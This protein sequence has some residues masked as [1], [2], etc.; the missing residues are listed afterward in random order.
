MLISEPQ[1]A[2]CVDD[3]SLYY[4][5]D[6]ATSDS[7]IL[8]FYGPAL[9]GNGNH[10]GWRIQAHIYTP[11]GVRSYSRITTSPNSAL[12][13]VVSYL[14]EEQQGDEVRRALS[15]A[16]FKYFSDLSEP[17]RTAWRNDGELSQR[18][19]TFDEAHAA[20]LAAKMVKAE[21]T[22]DVYNDV[23]AAFAERSLS[24]LDLDVLV[25]DPRSEEGNTPPVAAEEAAWDDPSDTKYGAYASLVRLFGSPAFLPTSKLQRAPSRP[26][27]L[28][29]SDVLSVEQEQ[30][31][32]REM[33]ELLETEERYVAKLQELVD[34][35]D[36]DWRPH[37][38]LKVPGGS[39]SD[40]EVLGTL[41]PDSLHQ[42]LSVNSDFLAALSKNVG[43][44]QGRRYF[45]ATNSTRTEAERRLEGRRTEKDGIQ[46]WA[47]TLLHWLPKFGDCYSQFIRASAGFP[48]VLNRVLRDHDSVVA[49]WIRVFGEQRLR[50][51]LIEPVQRLPRYSL[52]I[53]NIASN[54]P[55]RH[56]ALRTLLKARDIVADVCSLPSAM[57][58]KSQ[59]V[60]RLRHWVSSWPSTLR[61]QGRLI[62]AADYTEL[63]PPY[64]LDQVGHQRGHI[65]LLFPDHLVS[66][67][68]SP[69]SS[70]T[71]R[72]VMAEIDRPSR[73]T[74]AASG[75][76]ASNGE[77]TEPSLVFENYYRLRDLQF[78]ELAG[79]SLIRMTWVDRSNGSG[80]PVVARSPPGF[81]RAS[82]R[83]F[84]LRGTYENKANRWTEDITKAR[85]EGRYPEKVRE[86]DRWDFRSVSIAEH[87][88]TAYAAIT[89]SFASVPAPGP[90]YPATVQLV[91][92]NSPNLDAFEFREGV[93]LH[94]AMT[95]TLQVIRLHV[96]F[97]DGH[98]VVEEVGT[99]DVTRVIVEH[100]KRDHLLES[101][102]IPANLLEQ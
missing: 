102:V 84:Y 99:G 58:E 46:D 91:L 19:A 20:D 35:V 60:D 59:T 2:F 23:R 32:Q 63:L 40:A 56:L 4:T 9:T 51:T 28:N 94:I 47:K 55:S 41:F 92:G 49:S 81:S 31:I 98:T 61:P 44:S 96:R 22:S 66:V 38:S 67:W 42:I 39:N 10:A 74:L 27:T 26:L 12:Y 100:G 77:S 97:R 72:G 82:T 93:G 90:L 3:V 45:G 76:A 25:H 54:L 86:S 33:R 8:V 87:D 101:V 57:T 5:T 13:T 89:Q 30:S 83:V 14:S 79:G 7:P 18:R 24:S 37:P 11:A 70:L 53:D 43:N 6:P 95:D 78:S 65:F 52:F 17:V 34:R 75:A 16:L 29:R 80:A 62:S 73:D 36:H 88:F 85:V 71:A 69:G 68:K 48:A 50:A 15:I 64:R 21:N 1:P